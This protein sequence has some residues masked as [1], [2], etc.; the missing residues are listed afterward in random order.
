MKVVVLLLALLAVLGHAWLSHELG[1]GRMETLLA[2]SMRQELQSDPQ[3][4]G[5]DVE[6]DHL[7]GTLTGELPSRDMAE[8]AEAFAEKM[9][10]AGRISSEI[11]LGPP[12]DKP[13]QLTVEFDGAKFHLKGQLPDEF[14]RSALEVELRLLGRGEVSAQVEINTRVM[15]PPWS[16]ATSQVFENFFRDPGYALLEISGDEVR[17][18]RKYDGGEAK[19]KELLAS[20]EPLQKLGMK[21]IDNLELIRDQPAD[22]EA[23]RGTSGKVTLTGRLG[24]AAERDRFLEPLKPL[25]ADKDKGEGVKVDESVVPAEWV[26]A[27]GGFVA[28]FL[29]AAAPGGKAR[30]EGSTVTL[31]GQLPASKG[32]GTWLDKAKAAI[33]QGCEIEDHLS[34]IPDLDP[35][36]RIAMEKNQIRMEGALPPGDLPTILAKAVKDSGFEKSENTLTVND[37][38]KAPPWGHRIQDLVI[39][40]L[41]Q[42]SKG[43]QPALLS[44]KPGLATVQGTVLQN[45]DRDRLL[46]LAKAVVPESWALEFGVD[47]KSMRAPMVSG[48]VK[49]G[50]G[51]LRALLPQE[52]VIE[53]FQAF[54]KTRS[55]LEIQLAGEKDVQAPVWKASFGPFLEVFFRDVSTGS[56]ELGNQGWILAGAVASEEIKHQILAEAEKLVGPGVPLRDG[57]RVSVPAEPFALVAQQTPG[58]W[59]L[60]GRI[61]DEPLHKALRAALPAQSPGA[62]MDAL[63]VAPATKAPVWVAKLPDFLREAGAK[64]TEARIGVEEN[65]LTLEGKHQNAPGKEQLIAL[66]KTAFGDQMTIEDKTW[67]PKPAEPLQVRISLQRDR[68][69]LTGNLNDSAAAQALL[70]GARAA[71]PRGQLVNELR[72]APEVGKTEWIPILGAFL[73]TFA[74]ATLEGE[75]VVEGQQIVLRGKAKDTVSRDSLL[76]DFAKALPNDVTLRDELQTEKP[77]PSASEQA[78]T[79]TI[80]FGSSS[81][82]INPKGKQTLAAAATSIN[83]ADKKS[84]VLIKG[85]ADVLGD[86]ASNLEL[87]Q[88]RAKE[89]YQELVKAGVEPKQLEFIGVGEKESRARSRFD[90]RYDRKV[91]IKLVR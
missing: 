80:Y 13:S 18:K 5:V 77:Q 85:F 74:R 22:L 49:E 55:G 73:P 36:L 44:F 37:A 28:E 24:A 26:S 67:I 82:F 62:E 46:A 78:D 40:S 86:D 68:V 88:D 35:S 23:V 50:R 31:E 14:S 70:N 38:V 54:G 7:D 59:K 30:V 45:E 43:L 32:K 60:S 52:G 61:P 15:P 39:F 9:R 89:V 87:S 21:V 19:H 25:L 91:E 56:F 42:A 84:T 20:V 11:K 41:G 48:E 53:E 47:V 4:R 27:W 33:G 65:K 10:L 63:T 72:I 90:L 51:V 29:K 71:E 76:A 79:F 66:A 3:F 75:I 34:L 17:L 1:K 83:A 16:G 81:T 58:G 57:L 64:L 69:T 6:Y 12:P 8:L 2:D